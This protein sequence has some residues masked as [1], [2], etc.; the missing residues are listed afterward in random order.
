MIG[1]WSALGTISL[2]MA[3]LSAPSAGADPNDDAFISALTQNGI[4]I[5]DRDSATAIAQSICDGFDH[6][7]KPS[8]L[9]LKLMKQSGLSLKQSS[10]V[11]GVAIS[12]YCPEYAGHTD[13]S[14]AWLNPL[15]PL[16]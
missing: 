12:A 15:P 9:A 10:Y 2:L 11:V 13:N 7:Q 3:L 6:H 1:K 8:L 16:M 5:A 14:A 4:P